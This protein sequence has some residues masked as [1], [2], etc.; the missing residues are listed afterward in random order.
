MKKARVLVLLPRLRALKEVAIQWRRLANGKTFPSLYELAST[1]AVRAV[2]DAPGDRIVGGVE[3]ESLTPAISQILEDWEADFR[4]QL[5][6]IIR[7]EISLPDH[8]HPSELAIGWLFVCQ[9]CQFRIEY[10]SHSNT[11]L[12]T[13]FCAHRPQ[14]FNWPSSEAALRSQAK[15]FDIALTQEFWEVPYQFDVLSAEIYGTWKIVGICGQDPSTTTISEMDQRDFRLNCLHCSSK[16]GIIRVM[17]WR[18]A[19]R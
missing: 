16:D 5:G 19:V 17:N 6:C 7:N 8:V 12:P 1:S 15:A 13:H 10:K 9:N 3:L 18:S 11:S 2:V 4:A 14:A